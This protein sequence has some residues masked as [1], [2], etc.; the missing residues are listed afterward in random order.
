VDDLCAGDE[1]E[2]GEREH[3]LAIQRRLEGEVEALDRLHRHEPGR[4]K[5]DGDAAV[6]ADAELL[7][8]Q[9]VDGLECADL[10]L[11]EALHGVVERLEGAGAMRSPTRLARM[12]PRSSVIGPLPRQAAGRPG[13]RSRAG[14]ADRSSGAGAA[15]PKLD[16]GSIVIAESWDGRR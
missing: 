12:R 6:L 10:A 14:D 1:V 2:L 11:L 15:V 9:R 5:G 16:L 7:A 8:E 13:R 3:S 4:R